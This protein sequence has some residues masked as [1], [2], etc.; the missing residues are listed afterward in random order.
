LD[1]LT[2]PHVTLQHWRLY[3]ERNVFQILIAITSGPR[4]ALVFLQYFITRTS[5]SPLPL[6]IFFVGIVRT[7]ACGGW[8][9]IT[10]ND[11]HDAHD[12][13]MI[14]Y[15][16]CNAPW[17]LGGIMNT[18]PN[19]VQ[20]RK[21]RFVLLF[22]SCNSSLERRYSRKS[23]S[24]VAH[25]QSSFFA[26]IIPLVYFFIQH[27]VHRIPGAYTRYAFFEWGLIF[28]DVLYDSISGAD[29]KL[30]NLQI[31][32]GVSLDSGIEHKNMYNQLHHLA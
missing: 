29:F 5:R 23:L 12:V 24:S 31:A 2:F 18:P 11:D 13:L 16:V 7:L 6:W 10:S 28:L 25:I 20:V 17:M 3:P 27:K 32:I 1:T 21:R 22:F 8:V 30:C 26:L 19:H 14:L 4:F 9:Y 15:I